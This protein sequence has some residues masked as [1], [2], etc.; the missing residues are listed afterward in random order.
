MP[1]SDSPILRQSVRWGEE[2]VSRGLNA[3]FAGIIKPGVYRGF[4]LKPGGGMAVLVDHEPDY[5]RSVAVVERDGYSLTVDMA[6]PGMV[7]IPARGTWFVCIEAFYAP[8]QQGYQRIV[9]RDQA[10]PH[11]V[12][13]GKVYADG[14][15]GSAP[16]ISEDM[17]SSEGRAEANANVASVEAIEAVIAQVEARSN[18]LIGAQAETI[19]NLVRLSARVTTLE[20]SGAGSSTVIVQQGGSGGV[21]IIHP[22]GTVTG[23]VG[24][25]AEAAAPGAAVTLVVE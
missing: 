23:P 12:V 1:A 2:Y 20:I 25:S 17:I 5:P 18:A 8:A 6:D 13:L 7:S 11:H 21:S 3:K 4:R 14:I 9:V 24:V 22:D 15:D 10:E 19:A 16:V